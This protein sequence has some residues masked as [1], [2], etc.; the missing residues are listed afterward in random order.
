MGWH[1]R[2]WRC[3]ARRHTH[4][5]LSA[6]SSA[7]F[8]GRQDCPCSEQHGSGGVCPSAS[9]PAPPAARLLPPDRPPCRRAV[10]H[11]PARA[12]LLAMYL[13]V[14]HGMSLGLRL[15]SPPA[16]GEAW[17]CPSSTSCRL[18]YLDCW[19]GHIVA[20]HVSS[21]CRRATPGEF[22]F[23]SYLEPTGPGNP[24]PVP[25]APNC[26]LRRIKAAFCVTTDTIAC[27]VRS[28]W[29]V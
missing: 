7:A 2:A 23:S 3:S 21:F 6:L 1:A 19:P 26:K 28:T 27:V 14:S 25:H 11:H 29:P 20:S 18:V 5:T 9:A 10:L 24:P 17:P 12:G 16:V 8:V 22:P 15:Y 4:P 13:C